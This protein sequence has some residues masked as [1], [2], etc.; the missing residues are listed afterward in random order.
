[1]ALFGKHNYLSNRQKVCT[2]PMQI[3]PY[4]FTGSNRNPAGNDGEGRARKLI[5]KN[6]EKFTMTSL[7]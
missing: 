4:M 1:M 2:M 3:S 5:S 6:F 7:M